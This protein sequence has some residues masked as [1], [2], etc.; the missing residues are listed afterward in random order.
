[1]TLQCQ[2]LTLR[3]Q[4]QLIRCGTKPVRKGGTNCGKKRYEIEKARTPNQ[5]KG[6]GNLR[7]VLTDLTGVCPIVRVNGRR[8]TPGWGG[9]WPMTGPCTGWTRAGMR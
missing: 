5:N 6:I 8:S 9:R 7:T 4:S 1:M 2:G 3:P